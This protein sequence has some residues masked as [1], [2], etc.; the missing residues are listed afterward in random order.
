MSRLPVGALV[1]DEF[2]IDTDWHRHDVHQLQ[3]ASEGAME[4]EDAYHRA[5]LPRQLAAWIPA[6]VAHRTSL[7]RVRSVSVMLPPTLVAHGG[8]RIKVIAVPALLREMIFE[9]VR[10][11]V[12]SPWGRSG[13][14]P[15]S[16]PTSSD[17]RLHAAMEHTRASPAT[18]TIAS[19]AAAANFSVRTLRRRFQA[20][21]SLTWEIYR[22][23]ARLLLAVELLDATRLTVGEIA[24]RAGYLSQSAFA[25]AF[26]EVMGVTPYEFR[27]RA[28]Q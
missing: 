11:P 16:L 3:Y 14:A 10:W 12:G 9:A 1:Q 22:R 18:A 6:G 27:K 17:I 23:R 5:H 15:L 19:A 28:R 4:V 7:H 8:D 21:A 2:D 25:K 20:E 26:A 24:A 13:E